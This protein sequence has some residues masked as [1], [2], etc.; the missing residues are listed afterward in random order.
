MTRL[1]AHIQGP[2]APEAPLTIHRVTP[3]A[4]THTHPTMPQYACFTHPSIHPS[5][6]T[7]GVLLNAQENAPGERRE[8][9]HWWLLPSIRSLTPS[10]DPPADTKHRT[11]NRCAPLT[12]PSRHKSL[13][14]HPNTSHKPTSRGHIKHP[15]TPDA[16]N[17]S[18]TCPLHTNTHTQLHYPKK[19]PWNAPKTFT[20]CEQLG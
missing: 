17:Q 7:G 2:T 14:A 11:R 16:R 12:I 15:P 20:P 4:H 10:S 9:L 1:G 18:Q 6:Q 19:C 8:R 3:P 5:T 13:P